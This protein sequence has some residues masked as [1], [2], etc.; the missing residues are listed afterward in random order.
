MVEYTNAEY[1]D[2]LKI[3]GEAQSNGR[4]AQRLYAERYPYRETPSH[5]IFY[6]VEQRLR[7]RGTFRANRVNCGVQR[8]RR[9]P[10]FDEEVL[11]LI[12]ENPRTSTRTIAHAMQT[13]HANVW[14]VLQE[15]LIYPYRPQRVQALTP[16]DYAPRV[17]FCRWYLRRCLDEPRFSRM[18]LFTDEASF[19]REGVFNSRNSHFWSDENLYVTVT[20]SNQ[21]KFS[22]NM[23]AGIIN[24][25]LIGPYILPPRLT[26]RIYSI[27]LEEVLP[28]LLEDIP[29][30]IRQH[31][32]FQHDGAPAH[33]SVDVQEHLNATF[34]GRWI[35]RG[36]PVAWPPRS[37][38]LTPLD[39]FLW[40]HMKALVYETPVVSQEDLVARVAAAAYDIQHR[41]G[42]FERVRENMTRRCHACI[43]SGGRNFEQFL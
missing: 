33:F 11:H 28:G 35:G 36:G 19:T 6:R 13:N 8:N 26:G 31:L 5:T 30:D 18:I 3:Y 40:G 43:E 22:V 27:F 29:L 32:W 4:A 39:F 12:E 1:T 25:Y 16:A 15:Q 38:D 20:R 24:D 14:R 34:G 37:P 17:E 21:R 10:M 2:M 42:I 7:E 9:T 23:W 41:P